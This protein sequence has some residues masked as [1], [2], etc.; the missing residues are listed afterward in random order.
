[1]SVREIVPVSDDASDKLFLVGIY[2]NSSR[3]PV[4]LVL[5]RFVEL[6]LQLGLAL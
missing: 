1:M 4:K 6:V 3:S 2:L 5:S